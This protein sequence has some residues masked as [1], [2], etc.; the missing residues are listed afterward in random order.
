MKFLK[1]AFVF[2]ILLTYSS[3]AIGEILTWNGGEGS[4]SSANWLKSDGTLVAG[5]AY[6]QDEMVLNDGTVK[7]PTAGAVSFGVNNFLTINEGG[8]LTTAG[9]YLFVGDVLSGVVAS[10]I[11][12]TLVVDGGA[13]DWTV[14]SGTSKLGIGRGAVTAQVDL[15][16]GAKVYVGQVGIAASS[17]NCVGILNVK[18]GSVLTAYDNI[19]VGQDGQGTLNIDNATVN[20]TNRMDTFQDGL[21][22]IKSTINITNNGL[23][24]VTGEL[25]LAPIAGKP[26]AGE[27]LTTLTVTN[28]AVK[29]GSMVLSTNGD[30]LLLANNSAISSNGNI[31]LSS[32]TGTGTFIANGGTITANGAIFLTPPDN[33]G[34]SSAT[35]VLNGGSI[36]AASFQA[37]TGKETNVYLIGGQTNW[38]LQQYISLQ[39]TTTTYALATDTG[40]SPY[41]SGATNAPVAFRG[42]LEMGLASGFAIL[43]SD[44]I[45]LAQAGN[46][47]SISATPTKIYSSIWNSPTTS[48]VEGAGRYGSTLSSATQLGDLSLAGAEVLS[49]EN[50]YE[51]GY[52]TLV[53]TPSTDRFS[54][55]IRFD[56]G[57]EQATEAN[58]Q[59]L[60]DWMNDDDLAFRSYYDR[61]ASLLDTKD[62]IFFDV[63][64]ADLGKYFAFDISAFNAYYNLDLGVASVK[65]QGVPEPASWF[66]LLTGCFVMLRFARLTR[67]SR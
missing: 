44:T 34:V 17:D 3:T 8:K 30:S 39:P 23:L 22:P 35:F 15:V 18:S 9:A 49:F 63:P 21:F 46:G 12:P 64:L 45:L 52:L 62:G 32:G 37:G 29:A 14:S 67:R 55:E 66:L 19:W 41:R 13:I 54:F 47:F 42:S 61:E 50:S 60:A 40:F 65:A 5:A 27:P 10:G 20:A 6:S 26:V 28:S 53:G 2:G 24:N 59:T 11:T 56:N 51:L 31:T 1:Y 16:N 7:I 43:D 36:T 4:W 38:N 25:K 48:T 33:S 57:A 58:L